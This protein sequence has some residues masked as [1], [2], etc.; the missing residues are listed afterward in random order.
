[1]ENESIKLKEPKRIL[2]LISFVF[3]VMI[4]CSGAVIYLDS[5]KIKKYISQLC[6]ITEKYNEFEER[7]IRLENMAE[8][9][10][11]SFGLSKYEAKYYAIVFDDY[12]Q[13]YKYSWEVLPSIV[14]IESNFITTAKSKKFAK[15]LGQL[16]ESTGKG[17][18]RKLDIRYVE[19]QTLWNDLINLILTC[20]YMTEGIKDKIYKDSTVECKLKHG[21]KRYLGGPDY[22]RNIKKNK[23]T[24][25][26]VKDYKS[27][28][29]KEYTKLRYIYKGVVADNEK[30]LAF[31]E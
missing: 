26:Y 8:A 24:N 4:A 17:L 6:E 18:C 14:R 16:L 25:G 13:Q 19:S 23:H 10:I 1:M 30:K 3:V 29:W 21:I 12:A 2:I 7:R 28:V 20:E 22:L 9:M 31:S 5:I 15:G 27:T 11:I